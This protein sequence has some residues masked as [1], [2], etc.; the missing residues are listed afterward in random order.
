MVRQSVLQGKL[1]PDP[2]ASDPHRV[3]LRLSGEVG[4]PRFLRFLEQVGDEQLKS[5][6]TD[7]VLAIDLIHREQ[8][9]PERLDARL[10]RLIDAGVIERAGRGKLLL[11]RKFYDFLGEKG[12]HTRKKGLARESQKQLLLQH[13]QEAGA[14]GAPLQELLQVLPSRSR[15]QVRGLLSELRKEKKAYSR[16]ERRGGRWFAGEE[17]NMGSSEERT[18]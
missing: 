8:E 11:S 10:P 7:D 5:F 12:V 15:D 16:G 9:L 4:D 14:E 17:P 2:G 18:P 6:S 3:V 1:L 13:L